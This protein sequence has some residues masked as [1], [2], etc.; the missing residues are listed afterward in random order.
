MVRI[1]PSV[2]GED[3]SV[4]AVSLTL[5]QTQRH[6]CSTIHSSRTVSSKLPAPFAIFSDRP[7]HPL[8][9]PSDLSLLPPPVRSFPAATPT[10]PRIVPASHPS[11]DCWTRQATANSI[12]SFELESST[13]TN[14]LTTFPSDTVGLAKV[15]LGN[16]TGVGT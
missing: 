2:R 3:L 16:T 12:I 4:H 8:I 1:S 7:L 15:I 10:L 6:P 14:L 5:T 9:I 11:S 13:S